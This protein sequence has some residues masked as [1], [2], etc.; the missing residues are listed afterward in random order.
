VR[1]H[2]R[3]RR[4]GARAPQREID[5]CGVPRGR[6]TVPGRSGRAVECLFTWCW[7]A[8]VCAAEG[9]AFVLGPAFAMKAIHGGKS[10]NDKIDS[11]KTDSL[12]GGML[13]QSYVYPA[14]MR[15]TRDY[16]DGDCTWCASA[17]SS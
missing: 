15:S 1:L 5:A 12:L 2:S 7:L 11:H 9:I 10:N 14:T 17:G 16:C 8:N 6:R 13:P 3:R 4:P